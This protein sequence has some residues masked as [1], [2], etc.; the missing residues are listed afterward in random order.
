MLSGAKPVMRTSDHYFFRLSD[1]KCVDFLRGWLDSP[2]RLQPQVVNKAREWLT[3][4][5]E[6]AL[7]DWDI[8]LA[9]SPT[10]AFP[11]RMHR[12]SISTSGWMRRSAISPH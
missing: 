11:S 3:G 6:E 12:V 1:P 2:G 5:G 10:S 8:S 4:K 9:M 7:G